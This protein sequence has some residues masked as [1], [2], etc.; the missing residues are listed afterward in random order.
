MGIRT[1]SAIKA[2][3]EHYKI[4]HRDT[5]KEFL[6]LDEHQI[7]RIEH[8]V[9]RESLDKCIRNGIKYYGGKDYEF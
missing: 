7:H 1:D 2:F 9:L 3:L 6:D 4:I 5:L 8:N